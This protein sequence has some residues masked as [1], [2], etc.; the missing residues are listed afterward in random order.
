[1]F[2]IPGLSHRKGVAIEIFKS[3]AS[4]DN[5][6]LDIKV[7]NCPE[8]IHSPLKIILSSILQEIDILKLMNT[9][10]AISH[11]NIFS[12]IIKYY[13][14]SIGSNYYDIYSKDEISYLFV[15]FHGSCNDLW[16]CIWFYVWT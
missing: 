8:N 15:I 14:Y 10:K 9:I 6:N 2:V 12:Q 3:I 16:I 11:K 7:L 1:M 13:I 4:I 5:K